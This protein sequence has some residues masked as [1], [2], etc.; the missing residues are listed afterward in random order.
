MGYFI[1]MRGRI[2]NFVS[3]GAAVVEMP[4]AGDIDLRC[5]DIFLKVFPRTDAVFQA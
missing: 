2:L 3:A 4:E 5:D 1:A